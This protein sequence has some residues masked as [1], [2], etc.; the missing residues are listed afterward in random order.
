MA[1]V[2]Y[3]GN[4]GAWLMTTAKRRA[5][6]QFRQ[7][8]S[9]GSHLRGDRSGERWCGVMP[10]FVV[11]VDHVQDDVLRLMFLCCH[12]SLTRTRRPP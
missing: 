10:D 4:P 1:G 9:P 6:D 11:A 8:R 12:P 5:I 7:Q 2:G 3:P